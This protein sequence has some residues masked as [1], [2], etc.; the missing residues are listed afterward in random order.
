LAN[1][2]GVSAF[3]SKV[4]WTIQARSMFDCDE[5]ADQEQDGAADRRL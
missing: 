4:F 1:T 3:L 5:M 2:I